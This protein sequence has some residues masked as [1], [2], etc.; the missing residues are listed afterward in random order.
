MAANLA[1]DAE[2]HLAY[3]APSE[4]RLEF[5]SDKWPEIEF[6]KVSEHG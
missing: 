5:V 4:W 6:H 2:G 3:L 1:F